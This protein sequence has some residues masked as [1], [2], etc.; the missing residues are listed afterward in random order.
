MSEQTLPY[1]EVNPK[2]S[3]K[4]TVI[5]LHGLGDS[6]NGFAPIVPE[7]RLPEELGIRFIFPHAPMRAVTINNGMSMRA[8]YDIKSLDFESRADV[9]GVLESSRQVEELIEAEISKG[10]PSQR[11]VLAGFSQGG[12]IALHLGTRYNKKL[13]GIL[14]LSTYMSEPEKLSQNANP[15]NKNTKVMFCHGQQDDV[16][17]MFL[18]NAAYKVLEQNN[19]NVEWHDYLMQHNVCAQELT[20]I[21]NWLQEILK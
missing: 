17:P 4:A 8:W 14:A 16:V 18:G 19:Y 3:P 21:S 5:W 6:G 2:S 11:I 15:V 20:D 13:A 10:I 7:L 1:V 9:V 12:V